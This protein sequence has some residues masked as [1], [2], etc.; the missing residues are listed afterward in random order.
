MIWLVSPYLV[1][2][3]FIFH[4]FLPFERFLLPSVIG[5]HTHCLDCSQPAASHLISDAIHLFN[6]TVISYIY[7]PLISHSLFHCLHWTAT[8]L[9]VVVFFLDPFVVYSF[10]LHITSFSWDV[11]VLGF[12]S[13]PLP[14]VI[15]AI[16][17][18]L[19]AGIHVSLVRLA[20]CDRLCHLN[21]Y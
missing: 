7:K 1:T 6:A 14:C 8:S 2:H 4:F 9:F 10:F 16:S 11:L 17:S 3:A 15:M 5:L 20:A 12:C 13:L 19:L 21:S 18:N